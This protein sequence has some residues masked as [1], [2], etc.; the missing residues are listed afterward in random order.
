[1]K[2]YLLRIFAYVLLIPFLTSCGLFPGQG[3]RQPIAPPGKKDA[4]TLGTPGAHIPRNFIGFNLELDE[5]C[6]ILVDDE[7]QGITY[8]RLYT[9]LDTGTLHIGGHT[10]DLGTWD[11]YSVSSCTSEPPVVTVELLQRFFAFAKKIRWQVV[12]TLPLISNNPQ[13]AASEAIM[14]AQMGSSS[15]TAFSIGNEP[16]LYIQHHERPPEWSY[17][18]YHY[19]W[20][21]VYNMVLA[22]IPHAVFIGPDTCCTSPFFENFVDDEGAQHSIAVVTHHYYTRGMVDPYPTITQFLSQKTNQ[23]FTEALS[24]WISLAHIEGL[25]LAITE[26][27][28]ISDGGAPGVSNTF[29]AVLWT[30]VTMMQ[31]AVS[32][33]Q[34]FDIQEAPNASYNAISDSGQPTAIYQAMLFVHS[35]ISSSRI[36]PIQFPTRWPTLIFATKDSTGHAHMILVNYDLTKDVTVNLKPNGMVTHPSAQ[37]LEASSLVTTQDIHLK[38]MPVTQQGETISTT[39]PAGSAED[40]T[41]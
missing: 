11:P 34:Q 22:S 24:D 9:K 15:L 17:E 26:G 38:N 8:E 20:E 19:E 33:V 5:L 10:A 14:V 31:A 25:P 36:V 37:C 16:E 35:V 7:E 39:V 27:N 6:T 21:K 18:N 29:A 4:V 3:G 1:M 13:D 41:F 12:W 40:V 32:E 2:R 28:S 23:E 30:I